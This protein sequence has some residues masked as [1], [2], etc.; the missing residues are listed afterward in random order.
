MYHVVLTDAVSAEQ[1]RTEDWTGPKPEDGSPRPITVGAMVTMGGKVPVGRSKSGGF[2]G[3]AAKEDGDVV[4]GPEA[5][6]VKSYK[7]GNSLVHEVDDLISPV[8]LWRYCDQLR[9]PGF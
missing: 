3:W 1:L 6:I 4:I 2:L 7:L 9:I 8:V 5:R